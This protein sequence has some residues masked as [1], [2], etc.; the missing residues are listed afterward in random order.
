MFKSVK[1]QSKHKTQ[2]PSETAVTVLR[3]GCVLCNFTELLKDGFTLLQ[4]SFFSSLSALNH[5]VNFWLSQFCTSNNRS[6][7]YGCLRFAVKLAI[8]NIQ[9][10][11]HHTCESL[12]LPPLMT[13]SCVQRQKFYFGW[14]N[15]LIKAAF[16]KQRLLREFVCDCQ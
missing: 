12:V 11:L 6:S 3:S 7:A 1:C 5:W 16:L 15:H 4:H 8:S 13:I 10:K 9:S 2:Q 14:S